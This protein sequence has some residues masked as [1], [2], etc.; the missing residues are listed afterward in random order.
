[1]PASGAMIGYGGLLEISTNN[2][3]TWTEIEE[4]FNMTPPSATVDQIDVTHMQSPNRDREFILGLNDP[5]ECSMEVNFIPGSATDA[6]LLTIKAA[7]ARVKC[8]ITW[9]N[10]VVWS[11]DGLLT[12]YEASAPTDDKMT[13]TLTFKVSGSVVL[14]P[15]AVPANSVLPAVSG[16]A[17]VGETLT[18]LEGV[19]TGAP[20][21]TYQWQENDSGWAN[22]SGATGKTYDPV[23]GEVGNPLRVVVTG[24]NAAGSASATSQPTAAVLAE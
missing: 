15:A 22:I 17:Q 14:T 12:A 18:A 6:F 2:G 8:R 3:S 19:W 13:A 23:V 1:M 21:F 7:Y 4:V 11:F 20:T 10:A 5:G 24:T 9:P 16:I